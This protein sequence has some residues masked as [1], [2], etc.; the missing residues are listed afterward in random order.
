MELPKLTPSILME[1]V[2]IPFILVDQF[3]FHLLQP[4]SLGFEKLIFE[5]D[6]SSYSFKV[7]QISFIKGVY[8]VY[9]THRLCHEQL[10]EYVKLFYFLI[11]ADWFSPIMVSN[12][13]CSRFLRIVVYGSVVCN[14][15]FIAFFIFDRYDSCFGSSTHVPS[16]P[17]DS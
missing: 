2:T 14:I 3:Y 9:L 10:K 17:Q 13:F 11:A 8:S 1:I 5:L 16:F 12:A 7:T 4:I 15:L 6:A